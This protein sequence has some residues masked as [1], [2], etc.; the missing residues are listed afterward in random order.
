MQ[1]DALGRQGRY[2]RLLGLHDNTFFRMELLV[3]ARVA[4]PD[5]SVLVE[6]G[7]E[8]LIRSDFQSG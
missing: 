5:P 3:Y 1:V 6:S 4:D 2:Q 8:F 7:P